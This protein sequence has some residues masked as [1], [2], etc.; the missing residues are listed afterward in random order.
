MSGTSLIILKTRIRERK[1][2]WRWKRKGFNFDAG[3]CK[4]DI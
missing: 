3:M 4:S 1:S 2:E